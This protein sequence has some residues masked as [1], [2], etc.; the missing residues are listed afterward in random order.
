[1]TVNHMTD[2]QDKEPKAV[3]KQNYYEILNVA[4]TASR[5]EIRESYVRLRNTY[6]TQ[7]QALYSLLSDEEAQLIAS[8]VEEAFKILN[9]DTYRRHYDASL[10]LI[11]NVNAEPAAA[12]QTSYVR[13]LAQHDAEGP[14]SIGGAFAGQ[15]PRM[16]FTPPRVEESAKS[17]SDT[18]KPMMQMHVNARYTKAEKAR[19][20]DVVTKMRE[21]LATADLSDGATFQKLRLM[22]GVSENEMQERTKVCIEYIRGIETNVYDRLPR[23]VFVKGFLRSYCKYLGVPD[24]ERLVNAFAERLDHWQNP[25]SKR[26]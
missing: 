15:T 19:E 20:D 5:S 9:D 23:L 24:S 18:R 1:M 4:K 21:M 6:N 17:N 25:Q 10:G 2:P 7:N 14:V 11:P 22:C 8:Q 13:D 12:T 3:G 26:D 16:L